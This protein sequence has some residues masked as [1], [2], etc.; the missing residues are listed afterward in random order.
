MQQHDEMES[1]KTSRVKIE[2][3]NSAW[4]RWMTCIQNPHLKFLSLHIHSSYEHKLQSRHCIGK[5]GQWLCYISCDRQEKVKSTMRGSSVPDMHEFF[6]LASTKHH[7]QT[8]FELSIIQ[9]FIHSNPNHNSNWIHISHGSNG[10][11]CHTPFCISC[12]WQCV[13][14][15]SML[16]SSCPFCSGT[17]IK[18]FRQGREL[19]KKMMSGQLV[20]YAFI[21]FFAICHLLSNRLN[22]SVLSLESSLSLS[23]VNFYFTVI[24]GNWHA[25]NE[26]MEVWITSS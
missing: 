20:R 4:Q 10:P 17:N 21:E 25:F 2:W 18:N 13:A 14:Y 12:V 19:R 16:L 7:N 3:M 15:L 8:M 26:T 22:L 23:D 24:L 5:C 9:L 11:L 6:T 1:L